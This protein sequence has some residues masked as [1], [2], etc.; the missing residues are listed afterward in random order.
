MYTV[1]H[2][3]LLYQISLFQRVFFCLESMIID[4]LGS[5]VLKILYNTYT[6]HFTSPEDVFKTVYLTK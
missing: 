2:N 3:N 5:W 1:A 6:M 4:G